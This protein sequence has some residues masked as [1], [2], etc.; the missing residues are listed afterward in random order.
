MCVTLMAGRQPADCSFFT[1]L[2]LL[3]KATL[4]EICSHRDGVHSVS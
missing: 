2:Q 1:T 3:P 4:P